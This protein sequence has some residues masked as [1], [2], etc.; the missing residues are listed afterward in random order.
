MEPSTPTSSKP[1][2]SFAYQQRLLERT[3]SGRGG[4]LGRSGSIASIGSTSSGPA[5]RRWAP[6]HR[7][8]GSLDMVRGKWD[9]RVKSSEAESA[10]PPSSPVPVPAPSQD[11]V[12]RRSA[13][14]GERAPTYLKR[15][16]VPPPIVAT[17]LSPN[18][19]GVTVQDD[20]SGDRMHIPSRTHRANTLD[21]IYSQHTGSSTSSSSTLTRTDSARSNTSLTRNGSVSSAISKFE[22]TAATTS[23]STSTASTSTPRQRPT[24]L[25]NKFPQPS[26]IRAQFEAAAPP[27]PTT[28]T[29]V[30]TPKRARPI[31]LYGSSAYAKPTDVFAQPVAPPP[32]APSPER[33]IP[34]RIARHRS[35]SPD[36][37]PV[38]YVPSSSSSTSGLPSSSAMNPEPF[39]S[40]RL[41]RPPAI[42]HEPPSPSAPTTP[43]SSSVM[44][45]APYTPTP[46]ARKPYA[47][48]LSAGRKLG[49]HLPRIASG[50]AD[51]DWVA[52]EPEPYNPAPAPT[53][54]RL[55]RRLQGKLASAPAP[56]RAGLV[57]PS[58]APVT[59]VS[60]RLRL[61]RASRADAAVLPVPSGKLR[62]GLWADTQRH[63]LQAYE[64]LC[65]VGEAQQWIE[66]CLGQELGFGVVEMEEGLRNGAVLA[67]LVRVFLG[68][69]SVPKIWEVC[70]FCLCT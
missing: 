60:G 62:W 22:S 39:Y 38:P 23:T 9:E 13:D 46:R 55:E 53:R 8:G 50:D 44:T 56:H 6:A 58:S 61:S 19:T 3:S 2:G 52:P 16:S 34:P 30:E 65:H 41:H 7:I 45:P 33:D 57:A 20:V 68:E 35:I 15:Q 32:R 4:T 12:G 24:S 29:P 28:P 40:A 18:S 21:T 10:S 47:E 37:P 14:Y 25:Y 1:T 70:V 17:P 31:S 5:T 27:T 66:G 42:V 51:D 54:S 63:L 43:P 48:H 26:E 11:T 59:G 67:K 64:Y 49:K 36:K 69:G